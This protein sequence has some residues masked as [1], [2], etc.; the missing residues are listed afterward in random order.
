MRKEI[1]AILD[2][3][4]KLRPEQPIQSKPVS[5]NP[6]IKRAVKPDHVVV[7]NGFKWCASHN[8]LA[9]EVRPISEFGRDSSR[10]DKLRIECKT[11]HNTAKAARYLRRGPSLMDK[12]TGIRWQ[13]ANRGLSFELTFEEWQAVVSRPCVYGKHSTSPAGTIGVDRKDNAIGYT[14]TNS[15]ACCGFHNQVK[16][17]VFT[18]REM[19][20]IV[21]NCPSAQQCG[22]A[23]WVR[24]RMSSA[25]Q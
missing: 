3:T 14:V 21:D 23:C 19:L 24:R 15:A 7:P 1:R 2:G 18:Y 13:S 8:S 10:P 6:R 11:C 16:S 4:A 17:S 20:H 5:T 9:G 12:Y 25:I 22:T